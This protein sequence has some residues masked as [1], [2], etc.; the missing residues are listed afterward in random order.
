MPLCE[1]VPDSHIFCKRCVVLA[2]QVKELQEPVRLCSICESEQEI[3]GIFSKALHFQ[4]PQ[5][6]TTRQMQVGSVTY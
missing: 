1:A 4:E 6:P 3:D 2:E 5:S